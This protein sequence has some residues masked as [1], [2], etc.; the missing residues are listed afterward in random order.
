MKLEDVVSS[1]T[2]SR[3]E[4]VSSI[5]WSRKPLVLGK[6]FWATPNILYIKREEFAQVGGWNIRLKYGWQDRE[7]CLRLQL[8]GFRYYRCEIPLVWCRNWEDGSMSEFAH[9]KDERY[10]AG[11]TGAARGSS[12]H[13]YSAPPHK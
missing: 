12:W 3:R 11:I 13:C 2:K 8:L 6:E 9:S 10:L 1:P 5:H 4:D 7:L